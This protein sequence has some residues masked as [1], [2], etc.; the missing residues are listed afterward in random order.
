VD[1]VL[2]LEVG[3]LLRPQLR[4]LLLLLLRLLRLHTRRAHP[5]LNPGIHIFW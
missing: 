4:R 2:G 1:L 3:L 5:Q